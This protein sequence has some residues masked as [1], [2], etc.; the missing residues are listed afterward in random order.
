MWSSCAAAAH[1]VL[2][3]LD[4]L[5]AALLG[6]SCGGTCSTP[7][8]PPGCLPPALLLL[9]LTLFFVVVSLFFSVAVSGP[10]HRSS[11]GRWRFWRGNCGRADVHQVRTA[12]RIAIPRPTRPGRNERRPPLLTRTAFMPTKTALAIR[13]PRAHRR[14]R[15]AGGDCGS[16]VHARAER[17]R[18]IGRLVVALASGTQRCR[19]PVVGAQAER[20]PRREEISSSEAGS[21]NTP[22]K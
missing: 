4:R 22:A 20:C 8:P 21:S 17:R 1:E 5:P 15:R 13:R 3:H 16:Q 7:R 2:V 6:L 10:K 19:I 9:V 18:S 14:A 11:R 12:E